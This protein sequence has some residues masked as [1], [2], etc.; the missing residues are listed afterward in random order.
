MNEEWKGGLIV[1]FTRGEQ[2]VPALGLVVRGA[3]VLALGPVVRGGLV[4]ALGPSG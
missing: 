2:L 3:L 4:P 1:Y